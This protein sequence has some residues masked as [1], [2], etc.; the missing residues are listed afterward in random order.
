MGNPQPSAFYL[1]PS[2]FQPQRRVR[3]GSGRDFPQA[4][5]PK[6]MIRSGWNLQAILSFSQQSL[7]KSRRCLTPCLDAICN[8]THLA[9]TT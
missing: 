1:P 6:R 7:P 8:M 2:A 9:T 5:E 4:Y 3:W